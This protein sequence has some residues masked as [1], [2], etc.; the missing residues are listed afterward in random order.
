MV[1]IR[2]YMTLCLCSL[3]Q[4]VFLWTRHGLMDS[5]L[6]VNVVI[7]SLQLQLKPV[8]SMNATGSNVCLGSPRGLGRL[9]RR[10]RIK[11]L[12]VESELE[13]DSAESTYSI[14]VPLL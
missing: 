3:R 7:I 8:F 5:L 14:S 9:I 2:Q 10:I 4:R 11:M 12:W 1:L 6:F 13:S